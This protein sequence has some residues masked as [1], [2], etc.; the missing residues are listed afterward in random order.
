VKQ[1]NL[2][3]ESTQKTPQIDLNLCSGEL[4]FS[5]KSIPENAAKLYDGVL[6]WIIEYAKSPR[7]TTNL[8]FNLEY[9]NTSSAIWL[10]KITQAISTIEND[11]HILIL[12]IYFSVEDFDS[13]ES[14]D[15]L[16]ELYPL[17]NLIGTP[18]ISVGVIVYSVDEKGQVIK[19]SKV[20]L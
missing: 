16:D 1:K 18:S 10:A 19:E 15:M 17:I 20:F 12:H 14:E 5:G 7:P 8:R 2:L 13:M 11:E 4:I 9:F 3:I 6:K